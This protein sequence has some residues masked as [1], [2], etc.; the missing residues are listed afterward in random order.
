MLPAVQD[1]K[2]P[3]RDERRSKPRQIG[4]KMRHALELLIT[5]ECKTIKAAAERVGMS[6]EHLSRMMGEP[7]IEAFI[8]QRTRKTIAAGVMRATARS[9]ELLDAESEHVSADMAKHIMA[10][11]GIKPHSDATTIINNNNTIAGY[12]VE[13]AG[14]DTPT[15]IENDISASYGEPKE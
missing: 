15:T 10:I 6:R 7:H 5:G 4:R 9:I 14:S 11:G 3:L 13:I 1:E 12:V 8:A 2:L